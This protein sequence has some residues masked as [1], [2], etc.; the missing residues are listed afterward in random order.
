MDAGNANIKYAHLCLQVL[1]LLLS[2]ALQW[3]E[4]SCFQVLLGRRNANSPNWR[5]L[6][7]EGPFTLCSIQLMKH[8]LL[9]S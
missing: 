3:K 8:K 1:P 4:T 6:Y 5:V 7:P 9:N 2:P